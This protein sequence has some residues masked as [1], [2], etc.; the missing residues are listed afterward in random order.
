MEPQIPYLSI[1]LSSALVFGAVALGAMWLA[2]AWDSYARSYIADLRPRLAALGLDGAG[3]QNALRWW[4]IAIFLTLLVVGLFMAMPPIALGLAYLVFVSPRFILDYMIARRRTLLRDQMVRAAA[5]MANSSRAGLGLAQGLENAARETP[6]PL[7]AELKRIV[8]NYHGGMPLA[9][10]LTEVERRLDLE[11]FTMFSSALII[12]LERGGRVTF[13]LDR[14]CDG[15]QELQRLE[16]KMEA[17]TAAG[18]K[19]ATILALFPL[20]FLIMFALLDPLSTQFLFS[21]IIG[22]FVLLA[23][24]VTVYVSVRWCMYILTV[25]F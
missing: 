14:I 24:G 5:T 20:F 8:H 23:V 7:R 11:A 16:R 1:A 17:D 4:G 9:Q 2:P 15:L 10:A 22:Q 3:I 12:C 13:A 19:L 18:R 21:K 25:D 6:Q